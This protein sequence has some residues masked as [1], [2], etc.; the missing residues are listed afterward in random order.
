MISTRLAVIAG[1][2]MVVGFVTGQAYGTAPASAQAPSGQPSQP[3]PAYMVV[4][5]RPIAPEK[6]GPY[7][8]AAG[9]LARAAGMEMLATG[10]PKLHVLEGAWPLDGNLSIEKYRSMDDLLK[11]W[12]SPA[13]QQAKKLREGLSQVNFIVA[14]EGR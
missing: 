13:Y 10:D 12:N 6:M 11:F 8:T 9:P 14:I 5:S 2:A 7:R 3:R 1:A 4:S